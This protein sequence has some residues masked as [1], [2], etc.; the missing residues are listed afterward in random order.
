MLY[1]RIG[2]EQEI[3]KTLEMSALLCMV[4][5]MYVMLKINVTMT[6]LFEFLEVKKQYI[7]DGYKL[8]Y[9]FE[10]VYIPKGQDLY[11]KKLNGLN[12][13]CEDEDVDYKTI[14]NYLKSAFLQKSYTTYE[15]MIHLL[16]VGSD[17]G[18]LND[19]FIFLDEI[20]NESEA[21]D[22][23]M[24]K[25][26]IT[27]Q[28]E[29]VLRQIPDNS[30]II[31]SQEKH[32]MIKARGSRSQQTENCSQI[33]SKSKT[34]RERQAQMKGQ[35]KITSFF[36]SIKSSSVLSAQ[37]KSFIEKPNMPK[38]EYK[39]IK[40]ARELRGD[41]VKVLWIPKNYRELNPSEFVKTF[42]LNYIAEKHEVFL[43]ETK[44]ELQNSKYALATRNC[45][46]ESSQDLF[47]DAND[48]LIIDCDETSND[49]SDSIDPG[50]ILKNKLKQCCYQAIKYHESTWKEA[51]DFAKNLE[52]YYQNNL[53]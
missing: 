48:S 35:Q 18:F 44:E 13:K 6:E 32:Y 28:F 1:R 45:S 41:T 38:T 33:R 47:S 49:S 7:K 26:W 30:V 19:D 36:Q 46:Q 11:I 2:S 17:S 25:R 3:V 23:Q 52:C 27:E 8:F 14:V 22:I 34:T 5:F 29:K 16:H 21:L 4:I 10:T 53:M 12:K 20:A 39:F 24:K 37:N 15:P 50:V 51:I 42:L 40:M 9:L 31:I 43:N